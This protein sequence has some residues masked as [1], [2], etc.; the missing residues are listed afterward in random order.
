MDRAQDLV[1]YGRT[2]RGKTHPAT[3]LGVK[4]VGMGRSA[5]FRRTAELVP[6]LGKA[7][8]A[9]TPGTMPRDLSR[10]DLTVLDEFGYVPFDIDGACLP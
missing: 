5:G 6:R 9:G 4:A 7:K 2:G 1:F 8:R 3:A 10:A